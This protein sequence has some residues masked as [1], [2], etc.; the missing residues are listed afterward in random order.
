MALPV[1]LL[2]VVGLVVLGQAAVAQENTIKKVMEENQVVPDVIDVAPQQCINVKKFIFF[3]HFDR[4]L[5]I[6]FY[7][8]L[9]DLSVRR[10]R[11]ARQ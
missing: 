10:N 9:G 11:E 7:L 6:V 5:L 4:A 8:N 1:C 2:S 3:V